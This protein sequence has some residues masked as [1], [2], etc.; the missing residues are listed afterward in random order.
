MINPFIRFE[1]IH[2]V[3]VAINVTKIT[4]V[5]KQQF[6]DCNRY[7]TY[8]VLDGGGGA[9]VAE[10]HLKLQYEEVMEVINDYYRRFNVGSIQI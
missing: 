5:I 3:E 8:V 10:H 2:G 9:Y 4:S 1:N 7:C 6:T